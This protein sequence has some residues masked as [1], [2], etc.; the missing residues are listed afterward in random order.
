MILGQYEV[1]QVGS[2]EL[3]KD[4]TIFNP[5]GHQSFKLRKLEDFARVGQFSF[6]FSEG[7]ARLVGIGVEDDYRGRGVGTFLME[8]AVQHAQESGAT[9]LTTWAFNER[10]VSAFRSVLPEDKISV[11]VPGIYG[12]SFETDY[13]AMDEA[14]AYL[15][16]QRQDQFTSKDDPDGAKML[17]GAPVFVQATLL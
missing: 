12:R 14:I 9:A 11:T 5:R 13:S 10:T 16:K 3:G 4:R 6:G 1:P 17:G 2:C 15:Q 7:T 8:K